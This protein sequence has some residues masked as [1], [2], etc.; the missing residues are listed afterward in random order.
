[1]DCMSESLYQRV[2][3]RDELD[4]AMVDD[5]YR[6]LSG[7]TRAW[8]RQHAKRDGNLNASG[9]SHRYVGHH[10]YLQELADRRIFRQGDGDDLALYTI[11]DTFAQ[12]D[13]EDVPSR[14]CREEILHV[15]WEDDDEWYDEEPLPMFLGHDF[16][17]EDGDT[18]TAEDLG[19]EQ[20]FVHCNGTDFPLGM[21]CPHDDES[22]NAEPLYTDPERAYQ[23][24]INPDDME[25]TD[26]AVMLRHFGSG[27]GGLGGYRDCGAPSKIGK[28]GCTDRAP[29]AG[30]SE[31]HI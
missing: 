13:T 24:C 15:D 31:Q 25:A 17:D 18:I 7:G 14:F 5:T 30:H 4:D 28:G 16:D 6:A 20:Q 21:F 2:L 22:D 26:A 9:R 29:Y 11:D 19:Y 12:W 1:M 10:M 23:G 8:R 27:P 3:A